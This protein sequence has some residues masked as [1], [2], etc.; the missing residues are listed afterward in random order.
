MWVSDTLFKKCIITRHYEPY[1]RK[2]YFT[3]KF[4][5]NKR[6]DNRSV[7]ARLCTYTEGKFWDGHVSLR[8]LITV[9]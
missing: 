8:V 5:R 4:S 7:T 6:F 9:M 3:G 1:R 2:A